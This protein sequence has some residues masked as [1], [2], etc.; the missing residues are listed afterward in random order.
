VTPVDLI[1]LIGISHLLQPP[2]TW[3]LASEIGLNLRATLT[4]TGA[5][6][7][8]IIQNMAFASVGLPTA[9]GLILAVHPADTLHPGAA[10]SVALIV[11]VF[12]SWRLY[13]QVFVLRRLW[14]SAGRLNATLNFVLTVIFLVQGPGLGL[15][16][17]S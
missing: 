16:L 10:Q 15:L 4:P 13:R 17:L 8:Q 9:L 3:L 7:A 14:P 12:W 5:F 11:V 1:R 6:G 2:L